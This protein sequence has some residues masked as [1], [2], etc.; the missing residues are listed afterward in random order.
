ML[1]SL[2]LRRWK[3]PHC[4]CSVNKAETLSAILAGKS[5]RFAGVFL[6]PLQRSHICP[7]A[8]PGSLGSIGLGGAHPSAGRDNNARAGEAAGASSGRE[9]HDRKYPLTTPPPRR[10]GDF[11]GSDRRECWVCDVIG[12]VKVFWFRPI[13]CA[14]PGKDWWG[15][16]WVKRGDPP[17]GKWST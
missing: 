15:W 9:L 2:K 10:K 16:K 12:V 17:P 8:R 14:A 11:A 1:L 5:A 7:H 13:F 3:L 6:I 4:A